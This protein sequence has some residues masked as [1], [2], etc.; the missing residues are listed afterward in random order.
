MSKKNLIKIGALLVVLVAAVIFGLWENQKQTS[1]PV[2]VTSTPV[3]STTTDFNPGVVPIVYYCEEGIMRAVFGKDSLD[4]S[5]SDGRHFNLPQAISGSGIRYELASTTFIG[6]GANA[7]LTEKNITTYNNCVAG[8][9]VANR[10]LNIY[11]DSAK[12]FS[13]SYPKQ[14]ILSGGEIGYSQDWQNESSDLGLLLAVVRIPKDFLP[15]TNFGDAK[16][17]VGTSVDPKAI[18]NCLINEFGNQATS[19]EVTISHHKFTKITFADAGAGNYYETTSYRTMENNQCYAIEYTIHSS[20]IYNYSPDQ[21]IKE[22]DKTK[23]ETVLDG[24]M[25]SFNF[26]E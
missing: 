14:F 24:I 3:T 9:V 23:V 12:T 21:G 15:Q 22:F 11:N 17:T 25:Q 8:L 18:K 4:L 2:V 7:F 16:F 20:N 19:S 6:E 5:L 10:D 1:A 26:I 13:I